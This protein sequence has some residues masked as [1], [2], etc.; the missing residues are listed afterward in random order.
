MQRRILVLDAMEIPKI[1]Q[2]AALLFLLAASPATPAAELPPPVTRGLQGAAIGPEAVGVYV[3]E[4]G[5]RGKVLLS[6]HPAQAFVPAS[7]MKLVTTDAALELLGPTFSWKTEAYADGVQNGDVLQ[8][9]LIIK[10]GGDPKL[11][12]EKF[13]LFLRQL[14]AAGIRDIRGN[15]VLDRSVFEDGFH[16]V[17]AFDD[18]PTRPYNVGPDALLLN[19]KTLGFRFVPDAAGGA[20]RVSVEPPVAGYPVTAPKLAAGECGDWRG[21]LR[22]A[23]EADGIRFNGAY[24]ASC[25]DRTWYLN[26]YRMSPTRYFG[27]VFRQLWSELGG[28]LQGEVRSGLVPSGARLVG[29]W[30]SVALPEVIRDINKYSNNVMARQL[31]LTLAADI[32]KLPANPERGARAIKTWLANKGIEANELVIENGS[33]L[34]RD[35][36][37]APATMGRMLA[38][39]Y[40]SPLMPEFISSMPLVGYDGTMR[41]RLNAQTVSGNAHIKTGTLDQVRAIAGYVLAA[42]GKRYAVVCFI[43]H[44]NAAQ[45][46]KAQDALL[47]WVYEKG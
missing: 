20:V 34:S 19:Y 13:W 31:L 4:V 11:V 23:I 41:R 35:E 8:G 37:I 42:S 44:A 26:P 22:A 27:A 2:T 38:A 32:L 3:Q 25:G 1:L 43:N 24:P 7:T 28:S 17:A 39:A 36:R 5:A 16:D 10:G 14:R 47:Q 9:D 21:R 12:V 15:L 30:E 33:G 46:Q 6:A 45:G 29:S 18:E 40:Q